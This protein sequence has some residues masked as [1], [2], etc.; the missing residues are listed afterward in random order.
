[1]TTL[2]CVGYPTLAE[3]DRQWI[4]SFRARHDPQ[5]SRIG[6][7]FTLVF[8]FESAEEPVVENLSA[9]LQSARPIPFVLRGARAV[10]DLVA[11][12]SHVFLIPEE[13]RDAIVALHDQ[14]YGGLLRPFW[15]Q[16][17]PFVPHVT[18]A[19]S[20]EFDI[21]QRLADEINRETLAVRGII[22][23]VDLVEVTSEDVKTVIRFAFEH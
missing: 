12:G 13:G 19:G 21:C 1:V 16:D 9:I 14:L 11:G 3:S 2:A 17:I 6:A 7:H 20:V 23:H 15:R 5:A 22:E 4:E 10:L 18:V 8:P